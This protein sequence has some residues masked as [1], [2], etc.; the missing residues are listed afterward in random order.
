MKQLK[1]T[2]HAINRY[3]TH[4]GQTGLG[5][6]EKLTELVETKGKALS[7]KEAMDMGFT[8]TNTRKDTLYFVLH[9]AA[10]NQD[11]LAVVRTDG[12]IITFLTRDMLDIYGG[13]RRA[14]RLKARIEKVRGE[15]YDMQ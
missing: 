15:H 9:D 10:I 13:G 11:I 2:H 5:Y 1:I 4:T 8:L 6:A 7:P 14:E 12:T 3:L